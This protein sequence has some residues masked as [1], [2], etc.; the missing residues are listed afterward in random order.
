MGLSHYDHARA[1]RL[2]HFFGQRGHDILN[3]PYVASVQKPLSHGSD[4]SGPYL[5]QD[6]SH[7]ADSL[8]AAW[9]KEFETRALQKEFW[10]PDTRNKA[11]L[12]FRDFIANA[13]AGFAVVGSSVESFK[14]SLGTWLFW[15]KPD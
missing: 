1:K 12:E 10:A 11:L 13:A 15:E 9:E 7:V 8:A 5:W 6:T 3:G 2:L 4:F 14:S